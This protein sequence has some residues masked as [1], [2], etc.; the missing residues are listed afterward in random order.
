MTTTPAGWYPDPGGTGGLR[1]WDGAAWGEQVQPVPQ[2]AQPWGAAAPS[3]SVAA[4]PQQWG[5][6][7]A[8]PWGAGSQQAAAPTFAKQNAASLTALALAVVCVLI[9]VT[10]SYI[11]FALLPA[12]LA[13]TA[14]RKKEPLAWPALGV[15]VALVIW[16]FVA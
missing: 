4:G 14:V 2:P 11:V 7:A 3:A 16:R 1:W 5:A 13:V 12:F 15:A 10:T 8:E 9:A 6:G